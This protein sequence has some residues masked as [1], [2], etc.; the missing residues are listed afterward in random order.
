MIRGKIINPIRQLAEQGKLSGLMIIVLTLVSLLLSNLPMTAAYVEFWQSH[1]HIMDYDVSVIHIINDGLMVVF[2]LMI[3]MEIKRELYVGE[4][5]NRRNAMLPVIAAFGGMIV[6]AIIYAVFNIKDTHLLHGWAIPTATDIAFSLGVLSMLGK[7][8]PF[9]LKIFLTALA[10]IDD[11]GAI[12]IIALFYTEPENFHLS[13]LISSLVIIGALM[14]LS[15]KGFFNLFLW[16][17]ASIVIWYFMLLSGVHT[18]IAGVLIA[19]TIPLNKLV[20][21]ENKIH[22]PVNFFILPVFAL[23]NTAIVLSLDNVSG[24]LSTVGLGVGFGLLIGK[25]LGITAASW[26][27]VKYKWCS[28]PGKINLKMIFGA[29]LTAGIGFTMSIFIASLSFKEPLLLDTAKIAIIA[30]SVLS[31]I[32]GALF[33]KSNLKTIA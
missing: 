3:G 12:I 15:R 21:F 29:G 1:I 11:L 26:I 2:F 6:P 5:A 8:V 24:L 14:F 7:R 33:L 19:F 18:T 22:I 17:I 30:G 32:A 20:S 28:L 31:G 13:F 9:A 10:I 25:P 4:L 16:I 23:A 27:A